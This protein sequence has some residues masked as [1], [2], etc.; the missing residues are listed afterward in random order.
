MTA[1]V[2]HN[3]FEGL[4]LGIRIAGLP[5]PPPAG[6]LE[7]GKRSVGWLKPTLA[8]LFAATTPVGIVL[9]LLIFGNNGKAGMNGPEDQG[10]S[11]SALIVF[12]S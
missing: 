8:F 6:G 12:L 5:R 3:L 10:M 4:S 1:I 7:G 11:Y 2:F 9:G